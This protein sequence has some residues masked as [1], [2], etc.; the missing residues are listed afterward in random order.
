VADLAPAGRPIQSFQDAIAFLEQGLNY[1]KTWGWKYTTNWFDL[2]RMDRLLEAMGNPHRDY[3]V[4]HVAGTKGKGT[5][6]GAAAHC[7]TALGYRTGLLTSPHLVT[8]RERIRVDGIMVPE[9][10]FTWLVRTMQPYVEAQRKKQNEG[11]ERAPTYFEMLTALAFAHFA[12]EHVDWAVVEVGLGGRLDST[13]IVMPAC[14]VITSIGLDHTDK[15]GDTVE[16]IAAEKAG[17][18]KRG[19]PVLLGRQRYPGALERLRQMADEKQCPRWE[20]GREV[21]VTDRKPLAAR[22]PDPDARIGQTF[23]LRTPGKRYEGLFTHLLGKHQI[24]NVAAALGAL[25]LAAEHAELDIDH[26]VVTDAIAGLELPGRV[27][28]LQ[29]APAMVLDVAHTRESIT[30]LLE[31]VADH[32]PGRRLHVVFGCSADKDARGMLEL[33]LAHSAALTA[34]QAALRRAMPADEVAAIATELSQD[35]EVRV[36]PNPWEAVQSALAEAAPGDIVCATGSFFTAG[37]IRGEWCKQHP[38]TP[39]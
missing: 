4:L 37:E 13:N 15:L 19:V 17:I 20:V 1:E 24:D 6:S 10:E 7:F 30:A 31:A 39:R 25:E 5:T 28:V 8:A 18:L 11:S 35:V 33:L 23:S 21:D 38:E 3:R 2:R 27:E 22:V 9:D 16:A 26:A 32:F 12:Q 34:T 29:R 36:V 14:C